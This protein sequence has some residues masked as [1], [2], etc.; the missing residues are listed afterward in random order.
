ME[1]AFI[2]Q[3]PLFA[4]YNLTADNRQRHRSLPVKKNARCLQ[5]PAFA[6][7]CRENALVAKEFFSRKTQFLTGLYG[8]SLLRPALN[9]VVR[10][11][12]AN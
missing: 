1:T 5:R 8:Q 12:S 3:C 11:A 4:R 7:S 9:F 2:V 6:Q 10:T